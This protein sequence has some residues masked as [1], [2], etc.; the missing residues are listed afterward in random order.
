MPEKIESNKNI[1]YHLG[2]GINTTIPHIKKYVKNTG[3]IQI[4]WS[5]L[6]F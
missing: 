6:L 5:M 2:L 1:R 3:K 4:K